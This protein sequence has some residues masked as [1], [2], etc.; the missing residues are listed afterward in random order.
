MVSIS[1]GKRFPCALTIAGSDSSG[2][3]GIQADLKTFAALRVYGASVITA[4][5]AQNTRGVHEVYALPPDI[6][7]QQLDAI[8]NDLSVQAAKTGMLYTSE[9][10][11]VVADAIEAMKIP[12][13][14]DPIIRAKSGT[15]LIREEAFEKL[16][17]RLIPIATV[18][19]PN[20]PEAEKITGMRIKSSEDAEKAAKAIVDM[21]AKAAVVKGGHLGGN[22]VTDILYFDGRFRYYVSERIDTKNT[23]GTGCVFSAAIAAEL[24]KGREIPKAVRI[25]K[26]IVTIAIK[27]GLDVGGGIGPVDPMAFVYREAERALVLQNIDAAIRILERADGLFEL[28]PEVG[29]NLVMA[30]EHCMGAMD[31]A[32]IPGRI[33]RAGERIV[34][35]TCPTFGASRHV[36]NY[37]LV[38]MKYDPNVRAAMNIKYSEE[39]INVCKELGWK[40]SFYDRSKEP[41]EVKKIEGR[42]TIWGADVAIKALGQVPDVIYHRG[43][44]G[45][46]PMT[47]ILGK[48]AIDVVNKILRLLNALKEGAKKDYV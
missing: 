31:V 29:S 48:D 47:I 41:P 16:V 37:V 4:I 25:A 42:S 23:H 21:G 12:L 14:V 33:V 28:I 43:D 7:K 9:I 3:A 26:D 34:V 32:G 44:W 19:T 11:D 13:V 46:E 15:L 30:V 27:Y 6:V 17:K 35:T 40:V 5:T 1:K 20:V 36:A 24:A 45:K 2:G 18:V 10:I 8:L 38:A 22:V 39:I